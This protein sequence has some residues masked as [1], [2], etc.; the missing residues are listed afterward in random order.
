[1]NFDYMK[2]APDFAQL[3]TYC[4]EA[5]EFALNKPNISVT[6]ARKAM[7]Y[8]VKL[9]YGAAIDDIRGKTVFE[10]AT[11]YRFIQYVND[12]ILLNS[13]HYIRKMGNVAVHEGALSA[14]EALKVL[15][16]L[17]FLVG[18]ICI[19]MQVAPDYPEFEKPTL[20]AASTPVPVPQAAPAVQAIKVEV[21]PELCAIY[22]KKLRNTIFNVK[23]GRDESENKK[24]FLQAS[25]REAGW[26]MVNRANTNMPAS[27]AIDCKL[28][29]G[30]TVD[31]VLCGRDN[32]PLAIIEYTT[33]AQNLVEGRMKGIDKANQLE[34]KYGY[35]PVVYYTNGY[36]IYCI[37][38]LGYAPRRVFNFHS[39]EELELLKLR[40]TMRQ[41]IT[42]P[43]I[44]DAITNRD[45]QKNAI[46]SMCKAF[47]DMR[48]RSL[49]VMATGT[50]KTRVSI[51]CVDVLM[52]AGWIKNVLFLADRTSLVRQ[53][54]KNFNKLLP[55]VTTSLYTGGSLNRDVNARVIFST[56]QTMINLVNDDTREF[57][58]GRFDLIIIDEAHRSIFK[59]YGAL[60]N[61][62][63]ALM[64]GLTATPRCEENKSTYDTFQLEDG[65]PDFAYE[66][67]EAIEDKYLVGFTVLDKTTDKM[68]RGIRY[69]DL[70]EEEKAS[71]EDGFAEVE[72]EEIDFEGAEIEAHHIGKN[73][74][75]LGTID[76]MLND[77]MQ[78]GLKIDGGDM[79]GKTIIFATSHVQ[80][81]HI[82]ER[83]QKIYPQ[84][85]MDFCKLIDSHVE[86]NLT[87]IEQFEVRGGMPQIAVSVD[88]MDT[89]IDVPDVVNLVFFKQVRSK[90]KFLQMIGRGTRLSPGLYG[91]GMDKQGFQ[92]FDYFDNFR[93]FSTTGTWSTV[94][95]SGKSNNII[96]QTV[97]M[98][99]HRL[100]ILMNLQQEAS[101]CAFDAAYRDELKAHFISET[102]GL[103]NDDIQ[104]QYHMA[105]V[106][107]Y[108]TA[109]LWDNIDER[110]EEEII[111]HILPLFPSEKAPVKVK[112]FDTLIYVLE[113]EIPR[114]EK[115][116]KDITKIR[117]GFRSVASELTY[118]MEA[119]LKLKTIPAIV[120]QTQLISV[121]IDG[122]YLFAQFSLERAEMVR[123]TLRDLMAYLPNEKNYVVINVVD[124]V[125]NKESADQ[126]PVSKPYPQKA[127]EYL[128]T[129]NLPALAKMRN[130]DPLSDEEK[131]ELES[132][133]TVKLGTP[134]EF[135]AWSGGM[136]LL[137][138]L[139]L[140]L[141]I[142]E[143]AITTKFGSFL[144]PQT[145]N[146]MQ[147]S[148][149]QQ[150]ID[151][152]RKNGDITMTVLLKESPFCDMDVT[153]IF[154]TSIVYIK[155]L[156]N[157][158]HKPVM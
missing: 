148:Y 146:P 15:E 150:I 27:A 125:E 143:E 17:H 106:N 141:G 57:G 12:Q 8:V 93:Y 154:G 40:R 53:A 95:G 99:K 35:K 62:F 28:D 120:Q 71:W 19:L 21:A 137:P 54:H 33:T 67:E 129:S 127:Q 77:L 64:I 65:K 130:L 104:V 3:Y 73:V 117:N 88:M 49:L 75:N 114:L 5:E 50:G 78:N 82:V 85:G 18:E 116:G 37:D 45:Y 100:G 119:L 108:R 58:V 112:S 152:A 59:K 72:E 132:I 68:R 153:A 140:Q 51:S 25:L 24:L 147:M 128:N 63:D 156:I 55:N 1:M 61:Y 29:S 84:L 80:A 42:D 47:A 103:N 32:K 142:A 158:L 11:D 111:E 74:I 94:E 41:D 126:G 105:Y 36:Y 14:D 7:E 66:L 2:N 155:Q 131:K 79:L 69:D 113:K 98:N 115:E 102:R 43:V 39:I 13:I 83:F 4:C 121:M 16:E 38:Q 56:Y 151:Y 110:R 149:C 118:R 10:M 20:Q 44:D 86:G 97:T 81:V 89:G 138:F 109:E 144:N 48:R 145:L 92:I 123:K 91:P 6:S 101:L 26:P 134:A 122:E 22:A 23:H 30:D 133:F 96:P 157:G 124:W 46:R 135:S 9:L 70:T 76:A 136:D 139:R 107:K 34:K 90:I 87:L 60:F 31:Y 52:K